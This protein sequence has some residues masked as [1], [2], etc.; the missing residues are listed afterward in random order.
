MGCKDGLLLGS[1]DGCLEGIEVG[2]LVGCDG[3]YVG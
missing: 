3:E 2:S 1:S